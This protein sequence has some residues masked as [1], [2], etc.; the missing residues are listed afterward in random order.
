MILSVENVGKSYKQ[1]GE[2]LQ[3]LD[4]LSLSVETPRKVAILG[5]SGS[6]KSTLL[7]LLAGLDRADTGKIVING[8]DISDYKEASLAKFRA[9]NI[10]IIFQKFHLIKSFTA[11]ENVML[12]LETL[13]RPNV[14]QE[15][16]KVL[17]QVGLSHRLN[18]FPH[19]LS[20]GEAQRVAIARALVVRPKLIL[21]DEP[22][23]NLDDET[24][25]HV[26]Q[27]MF[28]L[29]DEVKSVLVL[30]THD[31]ELAKKCDEIYELSEKKAQKIEN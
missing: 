4:G 3:V 23:G 17:D 30:V 5:R 29:C 11:L 9:Q 27:T 21:A 19:Q 7:S 10:G 24:G 20:G 18:H 6:G 16:K 2:K 15:S 14:I 22:S 8:E 13:K 31:R 1:A 12:A 25:Q 28:T 26:M